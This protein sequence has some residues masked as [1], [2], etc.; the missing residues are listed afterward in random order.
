MTIEDDIAFLERVPIL[1]R[2]GARRL[3]IL[4]IGAESYYRQAG[5]VLFNAGDAAD[6]AYVVQRGSFSSTPAQAPRATRMI[7]GP[8]T[9]LG[10]SALLAETLRP[11][12]ATARE[13]SDGAAHFA[14]RCFSR[15]SKAI[16]TR[17]SGCATLIARR[18]PNNGPQLDMYAR[19]TSRHRV[20][21]R[22]RSE[23]RAVSES[24]ASSRRRHRHVVGWPRRAAIVL[25]DGDAGDAVG[26][27]G[28]V[29]M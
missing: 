27:R 23:R 25:G 28:E 20:R 15:C 1:R 7:V 21:A 13:D 14:Q 10:E 16:P 9:L 24:K 8:G 29:Q 18:A 6:C 26:E 4:A 11:A 2:L 19:L 22:E 3:R 5:E 12:T 17:R